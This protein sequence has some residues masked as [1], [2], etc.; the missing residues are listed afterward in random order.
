MYTVQMEKEC[1][2]LKKSKYANHLEAAEKSDLD[3]SK[4][5]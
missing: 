4:S 2:C 5:S 3:S 1:G